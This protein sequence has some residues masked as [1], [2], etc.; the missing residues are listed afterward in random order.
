M[1]TPQTKKDKKIPIIKLKDDFHYKPFND[2]QFPIKKVPILL[3]D[4]YIEAR[5]RLRDLHDEINSY[6]GTKD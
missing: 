2:Q 5:A 3:W 4:A 6:F 1:A